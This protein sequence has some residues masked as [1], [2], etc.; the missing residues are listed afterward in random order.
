MQYVYIIRVSVEGFVVPDVVPRIAGL[1]DELVRERITAC[2]AMGG[3]AC[4]EVV[5]RRGRVAGEEVP[6]FRPP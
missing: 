3:L 5:P 1:S 2:K 4:G 6:E